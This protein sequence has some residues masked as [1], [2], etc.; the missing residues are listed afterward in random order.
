MTHYDDNVER[1]TRSSKDNGIENKR[2]EVR[3]QYETIHTPIANYLSFSRY[4]RQNHPFEVT[5]HPFF[6]ILFDKFFY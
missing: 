3:K 5:S 4:S 2:K 6:Y 1:H